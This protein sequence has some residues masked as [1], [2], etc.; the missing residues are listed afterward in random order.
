MTNFKSKAMRAVLKKFS[1]RKS[2]HGSNVLEFALILPFLLF[3]LS[4][5]VDFGRF[6]TYKQTAVH[7][8]REVG[9]MA[10]RRIDSASAANF[11]L[12]LATAVQNARP[13]DI[14]NDGRIYI[15]QLLIEPDGTPR[16]MQYDSTGGLDVQPRTLRP[17]PGVG[18]PVGQRVIL[19]D[20]VT[21]QPYQTLYV[22]EVFLRFRSVMPL[23]GYVGIGGT[24]MSTNVG[25]IIYDAAYF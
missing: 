1:V 19:P 5:L 11:P 12:T 21:T 22:V 8:T 4:V 20:H 16:I 24:P 17:I 10:Y 9:M 14:E 15:A 6:I 2:E 7:L 3:L 23:S 18:D 25:T 13:V